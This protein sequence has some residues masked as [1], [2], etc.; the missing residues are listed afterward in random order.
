[1]LALHGF[2][3][4]GAMFAEIAAMAEAA[5]VAPDLPGHGGRDATNTAWDDAVGEVVAVVRQLRPGVILGYSMGGRL[6]LAAALR[7]P[8]LFPRLVLASTSL[9]IE[10]EVSRL[11]RR[12]SDE[13]DAAAIEAL[14]SAEEFV[15]SFGRTSF[16]QAP[17]ATIDLTS[18]RL[19]NSPAGVVGALRG[20][21]QGCHPYMGTE[22]PRLEMPI[23]WIAGD[24]DHK[25][26]AI[27]EYAAATCRS[28]RMVIVES[29][30]NV[31]AEQPA[32]VA[33]TLTSG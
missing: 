32:A 6:A 17:G 29:A 23:V 19:A 16:L 26:K 28:G 7:E 21:G 4:G 10:D 15:R 5:V 2:T 12:T 24:R 3:L 11:Q 33:A 22:L 9:G 31:I 8:Q 30:H 18:L 14:G 13:S 20:M 27:A 25:Y 1:M